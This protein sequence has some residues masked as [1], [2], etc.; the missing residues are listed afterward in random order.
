MRC[1][2]CGHKTISDW[3]TPKCPSCGI[4]SNVGIPNHNR[5]TPPRPPAAAAPSSLQSSREDDADFEMQS[6]QDGMGPPPSLKSRSISKSDEDMK[7]CPYCAEEIRVAAIKCKHCGSNLAD[8][9]GNKLD[10]SA[11]MVGLKQM[12]AQQLFAVADD[13]GAV[14]GLGPREA[15][16]RCMAR[17]ATFRGR[18]SRSEYWWFVAFYIAS[19]ILVFLAGLALSLGSTLVAI[20]QLGITLPAFAVGARRLHDT[21]RSGLYQLM[22]IVP[23]LIA[24]ASSRDMKDLFSIATVFLSL[25]LTVWLASPGQESDNQYGPR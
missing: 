25:V 7:P 3:S 13:G 5:S 23:A 8:S 4:E 16:A 1:V 24:G 19:M 11:R 9:S 22:T 10:L 20:F 2:N 15:V 12:Q 18:A 6:H 17:Y 21:G 14:T